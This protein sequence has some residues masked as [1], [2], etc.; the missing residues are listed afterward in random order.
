MRD[1][2]AKRRSEHFPLE[3][4]EGTN[5]PRSAANTFISPGA[6]AHL[7]ETS[8]RRF[9]RHGHPMKVAH[10]LRFDPLGQVVGENCK[11]E[12]IPRLEMPTYGYAVIREHRKNSG[13]APQGDECGRRC[14]L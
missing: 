7:R 12:F 2:R 3:T 4:A 14:R 9:Q 1:A 6:S 11:S 10:W 5:S 8:G 13:V